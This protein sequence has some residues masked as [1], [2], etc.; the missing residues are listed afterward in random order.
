MTT[1]TK[2]HS[3]HDTALI[4]G[5]S[6]SDVQKLSET[7]IEAKRRA[8]CP[9]SHFRVGCS[10]LLT[11]GT[12]IQGANVENA[13]Y[14]VGTCAERVTVATAVVQGA[15][16]GDIRAVAV[17]T[18]IS[19]PASP[20]GMCRQFLREFCELNMP[21]LMYDKDG[22]CTVMTLE[23]LLPMSF[24]PEKLLST[25]DI[26]HGLSQKSIPTPPRGP[27]VAYRRAFATTRNVR[28]QTAI[29]PDVHDGQSDVRA[30]THYELF[31][32]T[33]PEGPPPASPF[34]P[35]LRQLRKEFLQLQAKAHPDLMPADQKRHAEGLSSLINEAYRTLQ[36][37]L[38]RA[39]YLLLTHDIDVEDE[40]SKLS[41][42]ELLMDVMEAREAV[43]EA[44]NEEDLDLLKAENAERIAES[45]S[46]L[47]L[48]FANEEWEAAAQ[49]AI[50]LRYWKNIE[51]SIQGWEKGNGGGAIHH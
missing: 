34:T 39:Q 35:N 41:G 50:R 42:G 5:L 22:K 1:P 2:G 37:P 28:Q 44:E 38:K 6:A 47:D 49:E 23:Q 26:Q 10:I 24:G 17:A 27:V 33:F 29:A 9:Y 43:E 32:E 25:E 18:D 11:N 36:D 7:C 12:V 31:P 3:R 15:K 14:P 30:P 48:T 4:H 45:V 51:E 40:S 13:A 16:K 19:P 21:I 20:C 46:V 8:Y